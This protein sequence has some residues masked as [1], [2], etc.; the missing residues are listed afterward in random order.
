[1]ERKQRPLILLKNDTD[2][3][4]ITGD[5]PTVNLLGGAPTDRSPDHLALYYPISPKLALLLDEPGNTCGIG[6]SPLTI[7]DIARLN[8]AELRT[9][10]RQVFGNAEVSLSRYISV[11]TRTVKTSFP[12]SS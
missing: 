10:N 1:L 8:E 5:Q 11:E 9:S 6:Q 3:P 12:S 2:V 7:E 4:F